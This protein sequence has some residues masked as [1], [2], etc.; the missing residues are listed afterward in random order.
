[1][2]DNETEDT[3]K[4]EILNLIGLMRISQ[5]GT[6]LVEF[7]KAIDFSL[8]VNIKCAYFWNCAVASYKNSLLK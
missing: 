7:K 4:P 2:V 5:S 6:G 8:S 1:M 3:K